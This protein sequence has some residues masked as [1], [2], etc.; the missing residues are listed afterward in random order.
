MSCSRG[1]TSSARDWISSIEKRWLAGISAWGTGITT[2]PALG[3]RRVKV[4]DLELTFLTFTHSKSTTG[5]RYV[6]T[7]FGKKD[8]KIAIGGRVGGA[9]PANAHDRRV[10]EIYQKWR[11]SFEWPDQ[12]L[13]PGTFSLSA[14]AGY[15]YY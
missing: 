1:V 15:G 11:G 3:F 14:F 12:R 9:N 7:Y 10:W 13:Q 4:F 5:V 8:T 6:F 2:A